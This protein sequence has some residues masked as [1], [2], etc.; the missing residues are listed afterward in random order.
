MKSLA[1]VE[2]DYQNRTGKEDL[3]LTPLGRRILIVKQS[4]EI[5][6]KLDTPYG[7]VKLRAPQMARRLPV[8]DRTTQNCLR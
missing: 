8:G 3:S 7:P 1:D 5:R 2:H 6:L 4:S